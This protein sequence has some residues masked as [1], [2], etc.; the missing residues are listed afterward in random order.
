M[1]CERSARVPHLS[2][3][4]SSKVRS[5]VFFGQR[6]PGSNPDYTGDEAL[7]ALDLVF[8]L[9]G[10]PVATCELKNPMT[11]QTWRDAIRQYQQG[12]DPNAP[13][14][15]FKRRALVHFA[16]DPDEVHMAT[17]LAGEQQE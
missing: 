14:F 2:A 16:A 6:R 15:R 8:T 5:T 12:R 9:N 13:I 4:T 3:T 7:A 10:V 17:R 1:L 11:G